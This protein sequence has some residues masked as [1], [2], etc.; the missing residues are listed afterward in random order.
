VQALDVIV[1]PGGSGARREV[2]NPSTVEWLGSIAVG[3]SWITGVFPV[4]I[5][6]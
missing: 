6:S 5:L 4:M 2:G 3:C 1:I